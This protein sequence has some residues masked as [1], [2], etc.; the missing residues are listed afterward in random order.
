M[1][2]NLLFLI[3]SFLACGLSAQKIERDMALETLDHFWNLHLQEMDYLREGI[4]LRGYGQKNPLHEYQREGFILFQQMMG[5]YKEATVR[6]LYYF[7]VQEEQDLLEQIEG[8]KARRAAQQKKMQ[9]IHQSS[10]ESE[11]AE[12]VDQTSKDP[13]EQRAKLEAQRKARRKMKAK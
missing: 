12:A 8:E 13:N 10:I 2:K 4:G 9:M 11:D 6:K 3:G 7:E 1:T 5:Q